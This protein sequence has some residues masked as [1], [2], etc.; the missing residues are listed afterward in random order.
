MCSGG[1]PVEDVFD[2]G[3]DLVGGVVDTVKDSWVDIRDTA[4]SAAVV[5]GNY[6]L[7]GSSMLTSQLTSEGSQEQLN[8][9][10]GKVATIGSGVAGGLAGNLDNYGLG[11]GEES[12]ANAPDN[13]DAGGGWSPAQGGDYA[14]AAA[15]DNIDVGGG[16]N[17]A[18]GAGDVATAEAA[19]ATGVTSSASLATEAAGAGLFP[20]GDVLTGV[21]V[22][23]LGPKVLQTVLGTFL[24]PQSNSNPSSPTY[25]Q[26]TNYDSA[27]TAVTAGKPGL[28]SASGGSSG[29]LQGVANTLLTTR[30]SYGS[31]T[32]G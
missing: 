15:A 22:G 19:A 7:P 2:A 13:I 8:S 17:P 24:T 4:E 26:P 11:G 14:D 23:A 3:S 16:Y 25:V 1:N 27:N 29:S 18:T 28:G 6:F 10:L 31:A 9:T 20:W 32:L 5:A 12:V 21:A 30:D